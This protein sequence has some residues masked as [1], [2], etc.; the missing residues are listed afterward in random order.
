MMFLVP[1]MMFF[2]WPI[3]GEHYFGRWRRGIL[4]SIGA[5]FAGWIT[6]IHWTYYPLILVLV[7]PT[8]QLLF[9]D[10]AV[11]WIWPDSGEMAPLEKIVGYIGLFINGAICGSWPMIFH[12]YHKNW[13][14]G[15]ISIILCGI[16]FMVV[17]WIS[18]TYE[19]CFKVCIRLGQVKIFC[20]ADM[21][22]F[23]CG[24]FGA[25][26]GGMYLFHLLT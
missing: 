16:A 11:K 24:L 25:C 12:F 15:I 26:L 10:K 9:Y 7:W 22:W 20:P 19:N 3:G 6:G 21:W 1:I 23:A 8:Y 2:A 4:V 17:C 13:T 18:N 5:L 14:M